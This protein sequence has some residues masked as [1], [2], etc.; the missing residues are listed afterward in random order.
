MRYVIKDT[1]CGQIRGADTQNGYYK[2]TNIPYAHAK[3]W[4]KPEIVTDREGIYDATYPAPHCPQSASFGAP[5]SPSF[6]FYNNEGVIKELFHYSEDCQRLNIWAPENA[7]KAPVLVFIHGGSYCTGG[8]MKNS[9]QGTE[10]AKR[11]LVAITINYRLNIFA[12]AVGGGHTGNYGLWDQITALQWIHNN[13]AAF[14]G[15]PD[16]ITIMGESAGAMSVQNLIYSP[17]AKGLFHR[18][19]IMSGGGIFPNVFAIRPP[20][21]AEKLWEEV[22]MAV[23]AA[24]W[25]ELKACP[26]DQLFHTWNRI[27]AEGSYLSPATPVIDGITIPDVPRALAESGAVNNVPT[28][29]GILSEDM[30]PHTLY[31]MA[32]EWAQLMENVNIGPVYGFYF[33]RQLPGSD[34]GAYHACDIRYAFNTLG[35]SWRPFDEI[36]YRISRDMMDYFIN[37]AQT[38]KPDVAHL[39][40]WLPMGKAQ[41]KFL[42]FGDAPCAM[43]DVPE[44]RLLDTQNKGKPFPSLH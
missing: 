19:I 35:T 17:L 30:W 40:Q 25:E 21:T 12:S 36:D 20:A 28:I 38:G 39:A 43:V 32:A 26:A 8:C 2:F 29:I 42:N 34:H 15:D 33:D 10:Y 13:I 16:R 9:Y 27:C 31:K 18:A 7:E 44:Q 3:R 22:R 23:G 5:A 37:F 24:D 14:G 11:G 4:E 6:L 41:P 1:P